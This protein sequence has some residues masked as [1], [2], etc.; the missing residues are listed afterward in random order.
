MI[1][2]IIESLPVIFKVIKL[3]L[4]YFKKNLKFAQNKDLVL[5][6]VNRDLEIE[7]YLEALKDKLK[8]QRII[9]WRFHNGTYFYPGNSAQ[10]MTATHE[11]VEPGVIPN[12]QNPAFKDVPLSIVNWWVK[13]TLAGKL[14]FGDTSE[15]PHLPTLA[16]YERAKIE[17]VVTVPLMFQGKPIGIVSVEWVGE[18]ADL[19]SVE[20]GN[21]EEWS[22]DL[23]YQALVTAIDHITVLLTT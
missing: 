17:S 22:S 7:Q 3:T 13:E 15:V 11:V 12:I 14:R 23:M 18:K 10:K 21:P 6:T 1:K 9:V 4:S 5:A 2:T 20:I 16:Y 8:C 19:S